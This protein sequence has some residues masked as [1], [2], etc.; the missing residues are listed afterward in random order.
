MAKSIQPLST[1]FDSLS[2]KVD[3]N[4]PVLQKILDKLSAMETQL[5]T[6]EIRPAVL[7][8][9]GLA[10]AGARTDAEAGRVALAAA[11]PATEL[12]PRPALRAPRAP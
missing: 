11:S 2:A 6:M 8:G 3:G 4:E 10:G 7:Q 12:A 5:L 1:K 9:P